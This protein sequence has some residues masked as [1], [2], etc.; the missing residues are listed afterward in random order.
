MNGME[1]NNLNFKIVEGIPI[2]S[3]LKILENLYAEVFEDAQ[4]EFFHKRINTKENI[5]SIIDFE[6]NIPVGFKIGY[7]YN[8]DTFY[9][10]VGGVVPSFRN[11]GIAKKLA[12]MQEQ[13]A[14][15]NNYLKLR[16][17]SMNRFKSM[18][19]LNLK[20]GFDIVSVYTNDANQTKIVFEKNLVQF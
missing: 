16:T 12:Q 18:M 4:L 2:S 19:I 20:N 9:S 17:K 15:K 7:Y 6:N 10:W 1:N 8:K 3:D 14:K 5:C 13:W 11:K